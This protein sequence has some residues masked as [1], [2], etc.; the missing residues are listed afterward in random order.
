MVQVEERH[1][2]GSD[3]LRDRQASCGWRHH[4]QEDGRETQPM[5]MAADLPEIHPSCCSCNCLDLL[6]LHKANK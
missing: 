4:I 5:A 3:L 2:P 1:L 6:Q